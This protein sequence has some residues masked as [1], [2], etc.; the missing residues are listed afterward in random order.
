MYKSFTVKN[1][2]CFDEV[3]FFLILVANEGPKGGR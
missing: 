1:F 2:K 3:N